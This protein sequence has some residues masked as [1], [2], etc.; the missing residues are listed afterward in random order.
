MVAKILTKIK[1]FK[2]NN[3]ITIIYVYFLHKYILKLPLQKTYYFIFK[4]NFMQSYFK[5]FHVYSQKK[6]NK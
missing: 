3:N 5:E 6:I 4:S 1:K 2:L